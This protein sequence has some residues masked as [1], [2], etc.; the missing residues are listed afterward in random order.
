MRANGKQ[1]SS[2]SFFIALFTHARE[3]TI[4]ILGAYITDK[5]SRATVTI[6]SARYFNDLEQSVH[7]GGIIKRRQV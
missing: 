5:T 1:S 6:S 2:S 4:Q 3:P 7:N